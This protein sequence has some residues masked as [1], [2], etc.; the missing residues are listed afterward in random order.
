MRFSC[1]NTSHQLLS[2]TCWLYFNSEASL[3]CCT[4]IVGLW[5]F[6]SRED[7]PRLL[8]SDTR[9]HSHL[10]CEG[11]PRSTQPRLCSSGEDTPRPLRSDTRWHIFGWFCP[12]SWIF[13]TLGFS[14]VVGLLYCE[15]TPRSSQ[16]RLCFRGEDTPRPLLS[17]TRWHS[18]GWLVQ[19]SA[20][21]VLVRGLLWYLW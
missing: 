16:Q 7:I 15:G 12:C 5:L 11:T 10:Y 6:F 2:N 1:E 3:I 8:L 17:D 14:A 21:F 9:W 18:R 13:A 20:L 19:L 4:A